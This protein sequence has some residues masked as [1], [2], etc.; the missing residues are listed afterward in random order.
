MGH[1]LQWRVAADDHVVEGCLSCAIAAF[2]PCRTKGP[3]KC[4]V[5]LFFGKLDPHPP[6]HNANNIKHYTFVTLLLENLT[7][8]T[9]IGV[10]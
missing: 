5:T 6:P 9:P 3:F 7:P 2:G 4:Y 1:V 8:P 10:T